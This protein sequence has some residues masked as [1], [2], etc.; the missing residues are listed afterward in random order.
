[1]SK[2][3]ITLEMVLHQI[4]VSNFGSVALQVLYIWMILISVFAGCMF[5]FIL[6]NKG[7][8]QIFNNW[9]YLIQKSW[10]FHR[11]K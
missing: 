8:L 3:C 2:T 5:P 4:R 7:L 10:S 9:F 11:N 1:M 6:R